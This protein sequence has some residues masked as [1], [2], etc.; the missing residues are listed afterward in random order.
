MATDSPQ[1]QSPIKIR[2]PHPYLTTYYLVPS[3]K[4]ANGNQTYFL[5]QEKQSNDGEPF[6]YPLHDENILFTELN[7]VKADKVD[8]SNNTEWARARRSPA[9]VISWETTEMPT[10]G[11]VWLFLYAFFTVHHSV[12]SFR[13][14]L[15]GFGD[16]E[17]SKSLLLSMVAV[18]HP[19]PV[20]SSAPFDNKDSELLILR[21]AFW[22][23]CASPLGSKPIWLP[24]WRSENMVP[25]LDYTIDAT[26]T[27]FLRHP[28]RCPKPEP[29]ALMYSRYIPSLDEHFSLMAVD[30][31]NPK[32]L[33]LFHRWQ[34]DPRVAK[35]WLESGTLEHHRNYLRG[36]DEDPHVVTVF[37]SFNDAPFAYFE[38]YWAKEDRMGMHYAAADFDR[39]R[40]SLVGEDAFRGAHRVMAWWPS[41]MHYILLDDHR[42]EN[43]V[44]EPR[45]TG[46]K[47]LMYEYMFGLHQDQ[48][49]DLPH[50]RSNLVK[51]SRERFF[52]ICPFNQHTKHIAGTTFT[53]PSRL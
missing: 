46:E 6:P 19:R 38:I 21:S 50:K 5:R 43:V 17:L 53:F 39:G 22:Q 27:T 13:L 14:R 8:E 28:R 18:D 41:V 24:N 1:Q 42:T 20:D 7:P 51:C 49:I 37:G 32:H 34:N 30:Y 36:L 26:Q 15:K 52:Q 12:E 31:R 11:Q 25:H 45:L 44:G 2:L 48:Y 4:T 33:D 40:H 9:W 10:V 29:G 23:G 47:V 16:A 35:G 3:P